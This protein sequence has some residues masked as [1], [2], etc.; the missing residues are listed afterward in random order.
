MVSIDFGLA[1]R[2]PS[3][4]IRAVSDE[5]DFD[6]LIAKIHSDLRTGRRPPR[7][8]DRL[9][10]ALRRLRGGPGTRPRIAAWA[11]RWMVPAA[12][13]AVVGIAVVLSGAP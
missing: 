5:A 3:P 7:R 11:S 9:R 6:A 1:S 13:F 8:T 2:R 4:D 10:A 12:I